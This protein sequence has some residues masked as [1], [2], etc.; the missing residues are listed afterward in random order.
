MARFVFAFSVV[1]MVTATAGTR[2]FNRQVMFSRSHTYM[3]AQFVKIENWWADEGGLE[4]AE[5]VVVLGAAI[6]PIAYFI[7][8]IAFYLTKFYQITSWITTLP[9]P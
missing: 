5:W 4:A 7:W 2:V 1:L 8:Q 9:F 3:L 6:V